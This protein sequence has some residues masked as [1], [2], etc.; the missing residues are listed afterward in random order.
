MW[1]WFSRVSGCLHQQ[2][3]SGLAEQV[4]CAS[5]RRLRHRPCT[6]HTAVLKAGVCP[7]SD[8]CYASLRFALLCYPML[9]CAMLCYAVPAMTCYAGSPQ[10]VKEQGVQEHSGAGGA[11][12]VGAVVLGQQ[13]GKE[14]CVVDGVP[15]RPL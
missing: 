10:Q 2:G 9:C 6:L 8:A 12:Q 5:S 14:V 3:G 11:R 4:G 15:S 7:A 13:R 1:A